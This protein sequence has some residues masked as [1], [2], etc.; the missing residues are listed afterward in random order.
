MLTILDRLENKLSPVAI[1]SFAVVTCSFEDLD[2]SDPKACRWILRQSN[3][4]A[5]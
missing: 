4:E 3:S 5:K 2:N 1:F